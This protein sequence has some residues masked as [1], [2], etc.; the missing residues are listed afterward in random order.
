MKCFNC[1][2]DEKK[3]YLSAI[4]RETQIPAFVT[5]EYLRS[6]LPDSYLVQKIN[7][8]DN[9]YYTLHD[10]KGDGNRVY[11]IFQNYV[12]RSKITQTYVHTWMVCKILGI[13]YQ[14]FVDKG[15]VAHHIN[16]DKL[17]NRVINLIPMPFILHVQLHQ[18]LLKDPEIDCFWYI[19][20]YCVDNEYLHMLVRYLG[21]VRKIVNQ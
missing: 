21:N 18:A 3:I 6:I 2:S 8:F 16:L 15:L 7:R 14:G 19:N 20:E 11:A 9:N 17:D 12:N 4:E 10:T 13:S 5:K 1:L